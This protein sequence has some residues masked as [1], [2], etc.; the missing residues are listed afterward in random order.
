[1]DEGSMAYNIS[2]GTSLELINKM[3]KT[4]D[5]YGC[6]D[7]Y[8]GS[9]LYLNSCV[10]DCSSSS[11]YN[12]F[13]NESSLNCQNC[14]NKCQTCINEAMCLSC[15][16]DFFLTENWSCVL[17]CGPNNYNSS[18]TVFNVTQLLCLSCWDTN[19]DSCTNGGVASCVKC[20]NGSFL[21]AGYCLTSCELSYY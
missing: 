20:H 13:T 15:V 7:C 11:Q 1:M 17:S 2:C 19:C 16:P 18:T 8:S 10:N 5:I 9:H 6:T 21:Q 12:T 3:C 4:C 14:T